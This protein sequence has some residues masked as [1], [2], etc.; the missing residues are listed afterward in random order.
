M[1]NLVCA[2]TCGANRVAFGTL[3]VLVRVGNSNH[4]MRI[5]LREILLSAA[6]VNDQVL[7]TSADK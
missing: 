5:K 2:S 4:L 6:T 3:I 1:G 7:M